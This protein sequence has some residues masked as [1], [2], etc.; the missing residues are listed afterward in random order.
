MTQPRPGRIDPSREESLVPVAPE[1]SLAGKRVIFFTRAEGDG[2]S[3]KHLV[4]LLRR[5]E[6]DGVESVIVTLWD[7]PYTK[8]K[9]R[10]GF[11]ASIVSGEGF[12]TLWSA[13]KKLRQM[14]PDAMVFVNGDLGLFHWRLHLAGR[15]ARIPRIVAIQHLF[16]PPVQSAWDPPEGAS[17]LERF[18]RR[19]TKP[20]RQRITTPLPARLSH[21]TICV[22]DA[23]RQALVREYR[24]PR[25]RTV[26]IRNGVDLERYSR[27]RVDPEAVRA[28]RSASGGNP[29]FLTISRLV[30]QKRLDVLVD[31]ME[32]VLRRCPEAR[33][34]VVGDGFLEDELRRMVVRRGLSDAV[35]LEGRRMDVR[36]YL[37]AADIFVLPSERE[38]LPLVL[39]EAMA[40]GLPAIASDLEG[41][42]E[43]IVE[44]ETGRLVPAGSAQALADAMLSLAV[45]GRERARMGAQASQRAAAAFNIETSMAAVTR[46]ILIP[47]PGN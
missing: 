29:L 4:D 39:L 28:I 2:G 14:S 19:I 11:S 1:R 21:A 15:L 38:G 13:F 32:I 20:L 9:S 35:R 30:P 45:D 25:S 31:A 44:G 26:T 46:R 16:P 6:R 41:N 7:D 10:E 27:S 47:D 40:C 5:L 34:L 3:E 37:L 22:S 18:W 33:C 24:F 43:V 8:A 42:R 23:I 17:S 12:G 36:P